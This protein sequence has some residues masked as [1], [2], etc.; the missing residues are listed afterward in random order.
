M[1]MIAEAAAVGAPSPIPHYI[2]RSINDKQVYVRQLGRTPGAEH[3]MDS[4]EL[5]GSS[6]SLAPK[7]MCLVR[8]TI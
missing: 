8:S 3:K 2:L 7:P 5:V 6:L 4:G 1:D